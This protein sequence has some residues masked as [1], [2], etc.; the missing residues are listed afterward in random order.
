[1]AGA[2][3]EAGCLQKFQ[4]KHILFLVFTLIFFILL[5]H[6]I[7]ITAKKHRAL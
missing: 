2:D 6:Y 4:R 1:M 5:F 3:C 7:L